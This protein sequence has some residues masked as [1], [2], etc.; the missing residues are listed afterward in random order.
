MTI[1]H[2]LRKALEHVNDQSS[3]HKNLNCSEQLFTGGSLANPMGS[4]MSKIL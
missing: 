2:E 3:L 1:Q 4:Y